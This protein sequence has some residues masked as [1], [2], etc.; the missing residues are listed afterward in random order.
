MMNDRSIVALGEFLYV[1][2]TTIGQNYCANN[3]HVKVRKIWWWSIFWRVSVVQVRNKGGKI[4]RF[5]GV[6]SI[7]KVRKWR[8]KRDSDTMSKE[9]IRGVPESLVSTLRWNKWRKMS[10]L[11]EKWPTVVVK[12][13]GGGQRSGESNSRRKSYARR[14]LGIT[15]CCIKRSVEQ[16]LSVLSITCAK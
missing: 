7:E 2:P 16:R 1:G 11:G 14:F 3:K 12:V 4:P 13:T 6:K 5:W 15:I 9:V 10:V 8:K